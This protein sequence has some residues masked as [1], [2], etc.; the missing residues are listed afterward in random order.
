MKKILITLIS[1]FLITSSN[2]DNLENS[3]NK[4]YEM[5]SKST[6]D[7][8]SNILP[9]GPGDTEV[10]IRFKNENKPVG[11]IMLVRPLFFDDQNVLFYQAQ[12][13]NNYVLGDSRQSVNFGVGKRILSDDESYFLG[14]NSFVD[15]DIRG[16]ERL[17]IGGEVKAS[18]FD[19]TTN[20]YLGSGNQGNVVGNNTE[21]VLTGYDFILNGQLPYVPWAKVGYNDYKYEA[22]NNSTDLDGKI[23][24]GE[25]YISNSMTFEFGYDD[26][27]IQDTTDYIKLIYLASGK[28]R[29]T[30]ADGLSDKA[31]V[32]SNV[33][34]DM[35]KKVR[36]SN[37]MTLEVATSG[38]VIS[39]GN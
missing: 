10:S 12:V 5:G 35:L 2:A 28:E 6:E 16:N 34:K 37:I 11:S 33:S 32:N 13:N 30:I 3:L 39:N 17:S 1:F 9:E 15:Y 21:K 8:I 23:Y 22:K 4:L 38:V 26:N 20:Y 24:S 29:P 31:F 36:R 14:L 18:A 27:N 7:F 25:I 19:L